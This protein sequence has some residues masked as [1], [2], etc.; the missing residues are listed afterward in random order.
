[1]VHG[2][3]ALLRKAKYRGKRILDFRQPANLL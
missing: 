2:D 3:M 1:M